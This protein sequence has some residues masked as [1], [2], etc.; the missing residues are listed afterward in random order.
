MFDQC[1][2]DDGC[3]HCIYQYGC[4]TWNAPANL[5]RHGLRSLLNSGVHLRS[6][7]APTGDGS[8]T[9][10]FL[11]WSP[12]EDHLRQTVWKMT[13]R[14]ELELRRLIRNRYNNAYGEDWLTQFFPPDK[15]AKLQDT[16]AREEK[17]FGS[18]HH[19]LD[20]TY[21]QDL[22]ELVNRQWELFQDL[23]GDDRKAKGRLTKKVYTIV[24]VRNPLAHNR[25]V[26]MEELEAARQYCRELESAL[27][28]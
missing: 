26:P 1:Q 19:L 3:P 23:F 12:E 7:A 14:L 17:Q 2:C 15:L 8:L 25:L 11:A 4:S 28:S 10:D 13:G 6:I 20:Y 9:P 18:S 22:I 21:L 27:K 5:T 24:K 16:Q